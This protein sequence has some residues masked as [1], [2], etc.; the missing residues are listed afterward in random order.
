MNTILYEDINGKLYTFDALDLCLEGPPDAWDVDQAFHKVTSAL[1]SLDEWFDENALNEY[2]YDASNACT[3]VWSNV[4]MHPEF[5]S[6]MSPTKCLRICTRTR[7]DYFIDLKR[8]LYYITMSSG[9]RIYLK[10]Y[11]QIVGFFARERITGVYL[12]DTDTAEETTLYQLISR[13]PQE[14]SLSQR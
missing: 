12:L 1:K 4:S 5:I 13:L 10:N 3:F 11:D 7:D 6:K 8:N 9:E 2:K 14:K